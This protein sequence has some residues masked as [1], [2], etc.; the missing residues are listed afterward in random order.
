MSSIV[1]TFAGCKTVCV[2][3]WFLAGS[4]IRQN[5]GNDARYQGTITIEYPL[6]PLFGCQF[7]VARRLRYGRL[8]FFE[9]NLDGKLA[10]VPEWMTRRDLCSRLRCGVDP[11]CSW[12]ALRRVRR[13]LDRADL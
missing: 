10:S 11:V 1:G 6:H 2:W 9:I 5:A 8:L 3:P 13:L 12:T 4:R 7:A